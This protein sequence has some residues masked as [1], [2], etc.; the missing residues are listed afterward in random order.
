MKPTLVYISMGAGRQTSAIALAVKEGLLPKPD[1]AIFADTGWEPRS[2]YAHLNRLE[3]EILA[4]AGIPLYQVSAGN[5]RDD[6]LDPAHRFVSMPTFTLGPP[7][8]VRDP[9][10][11]APCTCG[12]A[13]LDADT[14]EADGTPL[15][16]ANCS[17]CSNTGVLVV[18]WGEP[19]IV[20]SRG[21]GRRQCTNEYKLRVIKVKARELLGYPHPTQVP[22]GVFAEQWIGISRDEIDR[23]RDSGVKYLRS[24]H[25][26][27][28]MT[29]AADGRKGWTVEDCKRYLRAHGYRNVPKSACI[30][31]P[32][33]GNA[34]WRDMRDNH[35]AEFAD[36]VAFDYALRAQARPDG[37]EE[38]LH[39]SRLPLDK[40]PIDRVTAAEWLSRQDTIFDAI[41]E[42]RLEL[43]APGSCSPHG[44]RSGEPVPA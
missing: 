27:L 8:E 12:W 41:S 26:L 44:C 34:Q 22:R 20:R 23:A 36:A 19:R 37:I 17:T 6:A 43:G 32:F 14:V 10:E 1:A 30:G 15:A 39:A 29:D 18:R 31:C 9:I 2:V 38:Y 4:P 33:H 28:D 35:P 42:E 11:T 21:M 5:I 24:V 3:R 25:P 40:A 7:V 16:P 13:D